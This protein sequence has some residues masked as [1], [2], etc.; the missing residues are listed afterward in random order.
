M[1]AR[2]A[3]GAVIGAVVVA[4]IIARAYCVPTAY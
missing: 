3:L 2:V 1:T 4:L